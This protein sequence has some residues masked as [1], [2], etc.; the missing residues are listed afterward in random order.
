[1][2]LIDKIELVLS[3]HFRVEK[4]G[5]E[6][7]LTRPF[8]RFS[9]EDLNKIFEIANKYEANVWFWGNVR[10]SKQPGTPRKRER[11]RLEREK[12]TT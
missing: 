1:M 11:R 6:L 10:V 8:K 4:A 2:R 3:K 12:T 5:R 7:K 9:R